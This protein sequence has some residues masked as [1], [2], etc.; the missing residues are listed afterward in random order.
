[1][2]NIALLIALALLSA[3]ACGD[4]EVRNGAMEGEGVDHS[5]GKGLLV[6]PPAWTPVNINTGRGDRLSVEQSDRPDAGQ[7]LH[8]RT[9]GS[10]A[11]VYQSLTHAVVFF[12]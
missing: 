10:D 8:V 6:T 9:F 5:D 11:G 7:C 1:M 12:L 3:V 2:R 4:A